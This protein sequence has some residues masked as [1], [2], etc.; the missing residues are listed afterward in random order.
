MIP[1]LVTV[2][3]VLLAA[4]SK[5]RLFPQATSMFSLSDNFYEDTVIST[6][7]AV[8]YIEASVGS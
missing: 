6:V 7:V 2:F 5:L 4:P 3:M 8:F 1:F